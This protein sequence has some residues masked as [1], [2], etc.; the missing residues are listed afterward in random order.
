MK[1]WL[2][3]VTFVYERLIFMCVVQSI[4]KHSSNFIFLLSRDSKCDCD[5][6][7]IAGPCDTGRCVCKPAVTGER[8]DRSVGTVALWTQQEVPW[9][10]AWV[11]FMEKGH[12]TNVD[13]LLPAPWPQKL[14]LIII[15]FF[16]LSFWPHCTACVILVPSPGMELEPPTLEVQS[17]NH[18]EVLQ[19]LG[20]KKKIQAKDFPGSPVVKTPCSQFKGPRFSPWSG[21]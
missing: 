18:W 2:K 13:D 19:K 7:G 8:C 1:D 21:N 20:F 9:Q 5:P 6:A 4:W 10:P 17:L 15:S 14:D 3:L 12:L 11:R 16:N